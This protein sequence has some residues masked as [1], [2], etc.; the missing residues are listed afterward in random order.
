MSSSNEFAQAAANRDL[1]TVELLL[2]VGAKHNAKDKKDRTALTRARE[3]GHKKA[4]AFLEKA[5][6]QRWPEL[7]STGRIDRF[8]CRK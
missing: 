6:A 8:R 2:K 4:I 3:K 5:G 7:S 1:K